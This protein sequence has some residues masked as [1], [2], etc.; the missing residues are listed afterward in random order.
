M[1]NRKRIFERITHKAVSQAQSNP[2]SSKHCSTKAVIEDKQNHTNP[3]VDWKDMFENF[4]VTDEELNTIDKLNKPKVP[5]SSA[6]YFTTANK[7][8]IHIPRDRPSKSAEHFTSK[9]PLRLSFHT[10]QNEPPSKKIKI[11]ESETSRQTLQSTMDHQEK[12]INLISAPNKNS[13]VKY[14]NCVFHGNIIN[15]FYC[16]GTDCKKQ[17]KK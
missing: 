14:E 13:F 12:N 4:D 6:P 5:E 16:S 17:E 2:T 7:K 1:E 8:K 15:N 10:S 11:A 3:A 9:P